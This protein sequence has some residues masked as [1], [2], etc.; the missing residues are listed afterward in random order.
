MIKFGLFWT[1]VNQKYV[2]KNVFETMILPFYSVLIIL[3]NFF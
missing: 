3:Q 1:F 2:L